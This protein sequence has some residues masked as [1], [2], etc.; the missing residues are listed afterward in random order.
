MKLFKIGLASLILLVAAAGCAENS[1]GEWRL[2][3]T[4]PVAPGPSR[5]YVAP[6]SPL[7]PPDV[8]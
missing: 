3:S 1:S 8:K 2:A 6:N 5:P 4:H 7:T